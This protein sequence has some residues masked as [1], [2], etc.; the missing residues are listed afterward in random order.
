MAVVQARKP[1]S[2]AIVLSTEELADLQRA[3]SNPKLSLCAISA[4]FGYTLGQ[5][6]GLKRKYALPKKVTS[7]KIKPCFNPKKEKG[8][9][10]AVWVELYKQHGTIA[11]TA[12]AAGASKASIYNVLRKEGISNRT[13]FASLAAIIDCS[14]IGCKKR[15]RGVCRPCYRHWKYVH[16]KDR[17]IMLKREWRRKNP[18]ALAIQQAKAAVHRK[19]AKRLLR[20]GEWKK[21]LSDYNYS[22]AYCGRDDAKMSIDHVIPRDKGGDTIA[23]NIV[24]ACISCNSAKQARD[25]TPMTP[26][27]V[28]RH[29]KKK[30][31]RKSKRRG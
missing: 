15:V 29:K 5:L 11:A 27:Q 19:N 23:D 28:R 10:H 31:R 9:R 18:E 8:E 24:P 25:W 14:H 17:V 1:R 2:S 16:S 3:W 4:E 6:R 13:E 7:T 12:R 22:C 26:A 20:T 21:I 30:D